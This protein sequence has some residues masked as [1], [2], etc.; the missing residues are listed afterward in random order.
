MSTNDSE[1][2]FQFVNLPLAAVNMDNA[3]FVHDTIEVG[4][5][6]LFLSPHECAHPEHKN[7]TV[8]NVILLLIKDID[9]QDHTIAFHPESPAAADIGLGDLGMRVTIVAQTC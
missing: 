1:S 7:G 9:G 2:E 8:T 3:I 6:E 5:G 4:K